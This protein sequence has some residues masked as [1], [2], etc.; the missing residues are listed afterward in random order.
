MSVFFNFC[1]ISHAQNTENKH[2]SNR[3]IIDNNFYL[4][5]ILK[6]Y[7]I[8]PKNNFSTFYELNIAKQTDGS[9]EWHKYYN[10]SVVGCAIIF[11]DLGNNKVLGQNISIVPNIVFINKKLSNWH[12]ETKIGIGVAYFNKKYN[13]ISNSENLLI[14]SSFTN[15][16]NLSCGILYDIS[17]HL[18]IKAA[19]S[20]FHFSDGHYQLPNVGLN[21]FLFNFNVKYFPFSKPQIISSI[22]KVNYKNKIHFNLRTGFGIHEF[23]FATKPI[24]GAKYPV[25]LSTI[26]L[27]KRFNYKNNVHLGLFVNYYTGFND[28]IISK[29]LFDGKNSHLK[30][31]VVSVFLGHEFVIGRF[32]IVAQCGFNIYNPFVKQYYKLVNN[33]GFNAKLKI[34]NSNKLG[35]QYY[36]FKNTDITRN[37][38]YLGVYIKSNSGQADVIECSLGYSF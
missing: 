19:A 22:S 4:G 20:V 2:I 10:Y 15:I 3:L 24:G 11:G 36:I 6:N 17:D 16:T 25:Y 13:R 26:Y 30:S 1:I 12:C 33:D 29:E 5:K 35:F 28:Y 8:F 31:M 7:P 18:S 38:L 9:K 37:N 27:S 34:Y 32:G 21:I 23:G 14:G